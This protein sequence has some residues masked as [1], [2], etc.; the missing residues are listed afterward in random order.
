MAIIKPT[1]YK[2]LYPY[3]WVITRVEDDRITTTRAT[4]T[5]YA[6]EEASKIDAYENKIYDVSIEVEGVMLSDESIE[7]QIITKERFIDGT[8]VSK[9]TT[10]LNKSSVWLE[11]PTPDPKNGLKRA[12]EAISYTPYL[13]AHKMILSLRAHFYPKIKVENPNYKAQYNE[14]NEL[15]NESEQYNIIDDENYEPK[16][17]VDFAWIVDD[18]FEV[19]P[20]IG[21]YTYFRNIQTENKLTDEQIITMGIEYG[22]G[23]GYINKRLYGTI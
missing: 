9:T 4:L 2:G 23:K 5:L 15:I 16:L 12:I 22:I 20:G 13:N 11:D 14:D 18:I 19:A 17:D 6:S 3:W 10:A 8:T 21:E 7:A 1:N